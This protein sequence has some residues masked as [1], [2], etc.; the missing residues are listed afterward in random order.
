MLKIETVIV[1]YNPKDKY[2]DHYLPLLGFSEK[3]IFVDNSTKVNESLVTKIRNTANTEY[4]SMGGNQGI[5]DALKTACDKAIE[6]QADLLLTLDQDSL[7]PSER[8]EEIKKILENNMNNNYGIIGLNFNSDETSLDIVDV[9]WWLTSGNFIYLK[10]YRQLDRGFDKELFIDGVDNDI[11]YQFHQKEYKVGYIKGISL[12]HT[13]GNPKTIRFGKIVF[14]ILNYPPV[15]YY[16]IFRNI[17]YLY[18]SDK[19]FFREDKHHID[20]IMF[21]KIVLFEKNKIQKLKAIRYGRKDAKQKRLG[22]CTHE[23]IL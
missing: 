2:M 23:D 15:R 10:N 13:I 11:G 21:W 22:R 19:E 1:L 17:N 7:F 8:I 12:K 4:I 3:V 14:S 20:R 18:S 6:D 5:A 9:K 16:Y